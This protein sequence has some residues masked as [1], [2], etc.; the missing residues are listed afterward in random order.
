M[1]AVVFDNVSF[2]YEGEPVLSDVNLRIDDGDFV[3]IIGPNGGGKTTL[4]K[5]ILGL[6][7]PQMGSIRVLDRPPVQA[8]SQVGYVPQFFQF[9]T[10]FP[11]RVLDVVLMGRLHRIP[12]AGRYR[13]EDRESAKSALRDVELGDMASSPFAALSGGQRQRALI[14]RAL[15]SE[16]RLLLLDEPTANIDPAVQNELFRLL[17]ELSRRL[18][19]LM[20]THDIGFVSSSIRRVVCVNRTV[21]VHPTSELTGGAIADLYRSDVRL[22]RHDHRCAEHGHEVRHD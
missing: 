19:I 16:P 2:A 9:D 13:P 18:T 11:V 14:A 7:R 22:V 4:L 21:V 6:L 10:S 15:A 12:F 17:D 1:H 20:V 8:R 3:S 5:L